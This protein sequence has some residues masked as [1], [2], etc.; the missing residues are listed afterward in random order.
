MSLAQE[1]VD[2]ILR[3]NLHDALKGLI[4]IIELFDIRTPQPLSFPITI[5]MKTFDDGS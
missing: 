1:V 2:S 4:K 5:E 3:L